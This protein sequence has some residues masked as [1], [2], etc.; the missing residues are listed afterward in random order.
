MFLLSIFLCEI[1]PV[2]EVDFLV[3]PEFASRPRKRLVRLRAQPAQLDN[4]M[5]LL[6]RPPG[7]HHW[8][9]ASRGLGVT[10]V[11]KLEP[12]Y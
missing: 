2:R 6:P 4:Y 9:A 12:D 7:G 1:K 11:V 8:R 3:R 10:S 5:P